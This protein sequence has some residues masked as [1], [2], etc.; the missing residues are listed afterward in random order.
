MHRA[1]YSPPISPDPPSIAVPL[2][3]EVELPLESDAATIPVPCGSGMVGLALAL[4]VA[5]LVAQFE[6]LMVFETVG[7]SLLLFGEL[8]ALLGAITVLPG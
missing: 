7:S 6:Q 5:P 4:V 8:N 2:V 1:T 3:P